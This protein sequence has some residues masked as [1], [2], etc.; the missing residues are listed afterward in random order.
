MTDDARQ[1][2]S[3]KL[4][5]AGLVAVAL[6]A[7][8]AL[9]AIRRDPASEDAASNEAARVSNGESPVVYADAVLD[10][11]TQKYI[12]D[13]EH[14]T[15]ELEQRLLPRVATAIRKR[16][17]ET[18]G[19]FLQDGFAARLPNEDGTEVV[20]RSVRQVQWPAPSG[21]SE[22]IA[23]TEFS[24]ALFDRLAEF[25]E[26]SKVKFRVLNIAADGRD[27]SSGLWSL[28]LLLSVTGYSEAKNVLTFDTTA[29]VRT[30]FLTD[31]EIIAG[32]I[33]A[34]WVTESATLVE[35]PLL[36]REVTQQSGLSDLPLHDNWSPD[37]EQPRQ[38]SFQVACGDWSLD[39]RPDLVVALHA[40][41]QWLL[42]Q[43]EDGRFVDATEECGLSRQI[44]MYG[45]QCVATLFDFDNDGD[46]DLL[47]G[48]TLYRN[49]SGQRFTKVVN[50]GLQ[51]GFDPMGAIVA[52][53]D[54]DGLLDLYVLYQHS[55]DNHYS[56]TIGWI[57]DEDSGAPNELWRNLGNGR[58]Q[59]VTEKAGVAGGNRHTFAATWLFAND[60]HYPDLYVAND[61][62]RNCLYLNQGNGTFD[63]VSD[64]S[65]AADFATSM[66]VAAGDLDG[67]TRP[68]I[69][70][71][72]MFS[73]MGRRI[74]AQVSENDYEAGVYEQL[75]GSCAGNR[76]YRPLKDTPD[77]SPAYE[78]I[79]D[80]LGING[81]GWAYAPSLTDLDLDGFLDIY[82]TAGFLSFE[83]GEP[84][85]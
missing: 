15:F 3:V 60:D 63:D 46:D 17:A 26:I 1:P 16:D 50:S 20:H 73:K 40:G 23:A 74:I 9:L 19:T 59:N 84:D 44:D 69:Y 51:L 4:W 68:E 83:R 54:C 24:Q 33:M 85:G 61:F 22:T 49:D 53:Y 71:A 65:G 57:N 14:F 67:D 47:L 34:E 10:E 6:C 70:V 76:L 37:C 12:W 43:T 64:S 21:D 31:E 29:Q 38:Y 30:G 28:R 2:G 18:L 58:F 36:L 56:G 11:A 52:D 66:G 80:P 72:N 79:S 62:A 55:P 35:S 8:I 81:V 32:R 25:H 78:D 39:G 77:S 27:P 82:A 5:L 7:A 42:K 13:L 45:R 41:E 48:A 75:K